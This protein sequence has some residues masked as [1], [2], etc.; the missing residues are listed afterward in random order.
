VR[1][2]QAKLAFNFSQ[3]VHLFDKA[4]AR[5]PQAGYAGSQRGRGC[6]NVAKQVGA[7]HQVGPHSPDRADDLCQARKVVIT[8]PD[9]DHRDPQGA[10]GR[11]PKIT[12]GEGEHARAAAEP[13]E[14][15]HHIE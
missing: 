14:R 9:P 11:F 10:D 2:P 1:H 13:L 5:S 6:K 3:G 7:L 8:L 12:T 15:A 4:V